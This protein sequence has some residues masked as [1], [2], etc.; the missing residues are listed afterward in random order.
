[1]M[2]DER[3]G[4]KHPEHPEN[5]GLDKVAACEGAR[6]ER[7][8]P[9]PGSLSGFHPCPAVHRYGA[10]GESGAQSFAGGV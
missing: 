9:E 1:M 3:H 4:T 2:A 8:E 6:A 5:H 7:S 10:A